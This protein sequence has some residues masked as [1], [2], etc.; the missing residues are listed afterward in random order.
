MVRHNNQVPNG[1]FKKHWQ[2]RV[3]TWFD[4]PKKKETRRNRRHLIA[5][6][7]APRPLAGLLRPIVQCPTIRYNMKQRAGRGFTLEE[8]KKAGI[9]RNVALNIGISIDWRRRNKNEEHLSRNVDRLK[10]YRSKLILFPRNAKKPRK[11]DAKPEELQN[12]TQ[13]TAQFLFPF[14]RVVDT[15][16]LRENETRALTDDEKNPKKSVV[17]R[18]K[19]A[20]VAERMEARRKIRKAKKQQRLEMEK[21]LE[22]AGKKD[23]DKKGP[24]KGAVK[25]AVKGGDKK[26]PPKKE[27]K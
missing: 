27:N 10:Q 12:A 13:N 15:Q 23:G 4:Q 9:D 5:V 2:R 26:A 20:R 1:H 3:R 16:V 17:A 25:G 24:V 22:S 11:Q 19:R 18:L 6:R 8:L 7:E 21:K 14:P